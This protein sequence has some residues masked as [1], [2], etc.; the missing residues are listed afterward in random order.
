MHFPKRSLYAHV[1]GSKVGMGC[2]DSHD[3]AVGG[4]EAGGN[5]TENDVFASEDTSDRAVILDQDG[6]GV[7]FFH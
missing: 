6:G 3:A 5:D 4:I 7:I 2:H 1:D